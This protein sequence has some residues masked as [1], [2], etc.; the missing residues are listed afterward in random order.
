[1]FLQGDPALP[2]YSPVLPDFEV[3]QFSLFLDPPN[4]IALQ[5]SFRVGII[6]KNLGKGV[7]DSFTIELD[8]TYPDGSTKRHFEMRWMHKGLADTAYFVINSKDKATAGNNVFSVNINR[9]RNPV[10]F[11]YNNNSV[12]RTIY[13]PANGVNLIMPVRYAIVGTDSVELVV[14]KSDLF[15]E[16]EDFYIEIDTTPWF[17]S[18]LLQSLERNN[19]PITAGVIAKWKVKLPS[20]RDTQVYFWRARINV[21][22]T[23]GPG[24]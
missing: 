8:R 15:K 17:N 3:T 9:G 5:D 20:L 10:E 13:I 24:T 23:E 11:N 6:I 16:S 7:K 19:T 2:I 21:P 22:A 1:L 18:T 12:T 4:T 14:Q